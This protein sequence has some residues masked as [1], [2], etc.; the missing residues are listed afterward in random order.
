MNFIGPINK[1]HTALAEK[2]IYHLP[3]GD[4]LVNMNE[5]IGK[6]ISLKY[7]NQIICVNCGRTTV[8]SFNQ[9]FC[10]PCFKNS[11]SAADWIIHPE[12]SKAH[13]GIEDRDLEYEKL[14]QLKPHMVYLSLT[15]GIKVGITRESQIPTRW[16]DQGAVKAI[17]LAQTPN[18]Y[19]A[20]MIEVSLKQHLADKTNWRQMLMN[21]NA[22]VDLIAEKNNI[23]KLLADEY[24]PYIL[25][26]SNITEINYPV[27]NYSIK[28]NSIG[29]D[30][31]PEY[32]GKLTG[33]KGQYLYFENGIVLNIRTYSGYVIELGY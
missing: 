33:I 16:I 13:L 21:L 12:L 18:R 3:I 1:M 31:V 24:Q 7:T 17:I 8:K 25:Q 27:L 22:D 26:D 23:K 11:A 10:Y 29:F 14:V 4:D 19:L 5:L 15:S 28:V 20:G 9:G 2:V 30:K 6:E 32:T